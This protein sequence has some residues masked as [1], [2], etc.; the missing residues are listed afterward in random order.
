MR[1]NEEVNQ[2]LPKLVN[3][4]HK[5]LCLS[6]AQSGRMVEAGSDLRASMNEGVTSHSQSFFPILLGQ[7]G[8]IIVIVWPRESILS[9]LT[10]TS[11]L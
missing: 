7:T 10:G 5:L 6:R 1:L 2:T 8:T 4:G 9:L 11:V 3:R